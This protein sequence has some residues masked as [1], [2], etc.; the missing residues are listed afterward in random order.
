MSSTEP[1]SANGSQEA[2]A[3]DASVVKALSTDVEGLEE[4][5]VVYDLSDEDDVRRSLPSSSP[6]S[7]RFGSGLITD[8][9]SWVVYDYS[10]LANQEDDSDSEDDDDDD[11]GEDDDGSGAE[12]AGPG[13]AYL[14]VCL[15]SLSALLLSISSR[16]LTTCLLSVYFF[17]GLRLCLGIVP[18]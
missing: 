11:D 16:R 15:S 3:A 6:S 13:L 2:A 12:A 18:W 17:C 9:L 14:Y 10:A 5:N 8:K 7:V 4:D 1:T